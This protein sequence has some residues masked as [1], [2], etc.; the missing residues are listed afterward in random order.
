MNANSSG[1]ILDSS[2]LIDFNQNPRRLDRYI[3]G[4]TIYHIDDIEEELF[5]HYLELLKN[6]KK[7]ERAT[8]RTLQETFKTTLLH[9]SKPAENEVSEKPE[10]SVKSEML[11]KLEL[12]RLDPEQLDKESSKI[13][14]TIVAYA[15]VHNL[16]VM[17]KDK[18][19][20]VMRELFG[21]YVTIYTPGLDPLDRSRKKQ[22]EVSLRKNREILPIVLSSVEKRK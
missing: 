11:Q 6:K 15:I 3:K 8:N 22:L 5:K 4:K 14:I 7:A 21:H 19:F 12:A 1:V 2:I 17:A 9:S 20:L 13:D 18:L 10:I 16:E